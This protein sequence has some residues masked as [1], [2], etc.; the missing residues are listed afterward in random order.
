MHKFSVDAKVEAKMGLNKLCGRELNADRLILIW[1][2]INSDRV[3][4][5]HDIPSGCFLCD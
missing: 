1:K 2:T 3:R 5:F 4:A